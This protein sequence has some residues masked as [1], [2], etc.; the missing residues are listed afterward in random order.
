MMRLFANAICY[1]NVIGRWLPPGRSPG[2][3][4]VADA[5]STPSGAA[6]GR[7]QNSCNQSRQGKY[8]SLRC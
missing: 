5:D 1:R 4:R 7:E 3:F 6:P 2:W 8:R